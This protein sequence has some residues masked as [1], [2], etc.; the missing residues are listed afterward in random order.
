MRNRAQ[1]ICSELFVLR[2][3]CRVI[4]FL[5]VSQIVKRQRKFADYLKHNAF[6]EGIEL[7]IADG[8]SKNAVSSVIDA[9]CEIQAL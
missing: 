5:D 4:F 3:N 9:R 1:Q 8:N 7:I 6:L 2:Q